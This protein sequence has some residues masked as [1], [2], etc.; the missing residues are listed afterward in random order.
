MASVTALPFATGAFDVV[1]CNHVIE[2]V[3]GPGAVVTELA[4]VLRPG[5]LAIIGVPNEGCAMAWLRNHVLQR[6]VLK[7]T[8]HVNF[9]TRGSLL[10]LLGRAP[11]VVEDV[12]AGGLFVPH[13]RLS[14]LFTASPRGRALL[15]LAGRLWPSQAA[16]LTAIATRRA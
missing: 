5:G 8:D 1:L 9:F 13:H 6:S 12:R 7:T 15:D 3:P 10:R 4:R 16:D 11:L 14:R 2:H